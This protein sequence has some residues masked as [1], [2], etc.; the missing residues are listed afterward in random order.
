VSVY[1][2]SSA[3]AVIL[4]AE[5]QAPTL[6]SWLRDLAEPLVSTQLLETEMRRVGL[7]HGLDQSVVTDLLA[8]VSLTVLRKADFTA[9][10]LLGGAGLRSL[11]ALHLQGALRLDARTILTYDRRL[12]EAAGSI[13]LEVVAPA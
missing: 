8:A 3:L 9:A 1:V 5:P 6:L 11:D 13:G 4:R 2:D 7:R 10:G 12:A